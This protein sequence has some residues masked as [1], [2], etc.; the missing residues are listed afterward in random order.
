MNYLT[1]N[2]RNLT[3]AIIPVDRTDTKIWLYSLILISTSSVAISYLG[4][5][6]L[7][8]PVLVLIVFLTIRFKIFPLAFYLFT[9]PFAMRFMGN[10][11]VAYCLIYA[12][13]IILFALLRSIVLPNAQ[14][15]ISKTLLSFWVIFI[16]IALL[17]SLNNGMTITGLR[18]IIRFCIFMLLIFTI[19]DLYEP[20]YFFW[21]LGAM[22]IPLVVSALN[23][24]WI[25]SQAKGLLSLLE[26]YRTKP[27]GIYPNSNTLGCVL[28]VTLPPWIAMSIWHKRPSMRLLSK[29]IA[30]LLFLALLLTNSRA[31]MVGIFIATTLFFIWTKKLKY[32]AA[33]LLA[34][35][36]ILAALPG[37]RNMISFGLRIERGAS[38][39]GDVW[40]NTIDMI[41]N[42]PLLGIG[43]GNYSS[44]YEQYFKL[45]WEK[46]IFRSMPNAHN[47]ILNLLAFYGLASIPIIFFLFYFP[48]KKGIGVIKKRISHEDKIFIYG[49][50]AGI[51]ALYGLSLFEAG[52][53]LEDGRPYP[54]MLFWVLFAIILKTNDF[55]SRQDDNMHVKA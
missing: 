40:R 41:S 2:F 10:Y 20:K 3:T 31:A 37:V 44:Y 51:A 27:G 47:L 29:G 45:K 24:M 39:R 30:G 15:R 36:I 46:E 8:I 4:P 12:I 22:T 43:P 14:F 28:M 52:A 21:L 18:A 7:I 26:L 49:A 13:V 16:I 23:L 42:N 17:S 5:K 19:Y 11:Y 50:V 48:I 55:Y 34:V 9:I 1:A 53:I 6:S 38:N 33:I 25:Y 54:D 35:V 32:F